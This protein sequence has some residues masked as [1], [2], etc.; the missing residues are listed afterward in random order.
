MKMAFAN[1]FLI[2]QGLPAIKPR[3][4]TAS[5]FDLANKCIKTFTTWKFDLEEY[6]TETL[7]RLSDIE[8]E[9]I[10]ASS[11][12]KLNHEEQTTLVARFIRDN[13]VEP[14][15]HLFNA[16]NL[17]T[18]MFSLIAAYAWTV[19]EPETRIKLYQ[20]IWNAYKPETNC[21]EQYT[22]TGNVK[23]H[24]FPWQSNFMSLNFEHTEL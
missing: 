6:K 24:I 23:C 13:L 22:P 7:A 21:E 12:N 1:T 14:F 18:K 10:T 5:L 2:S 17:V 8:K 9:Y 15:Q 20:A 3:K 19:E 11:F 4:L 16:R